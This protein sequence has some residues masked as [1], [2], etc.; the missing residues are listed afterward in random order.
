MRE[1]HPIISPFLTGFNDLVK[2]RKLSTESFYTIIILEEEFGF[3]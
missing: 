1:K 3:E 2:M